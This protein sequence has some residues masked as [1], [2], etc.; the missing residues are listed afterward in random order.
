MRVATHRQVIPIS[1]QEVEGVKLRLAQGVVRRAV[2]AEGHHIELQIGR[3]PSSAG[4]SDP[5]G[6]HK[7]GTAQ[8]RPEPP[9]LAGESWSRSPQGG[10]RF[11]RWPGTGSV[12][13]A[14]CFCETSKRVHSNR[15]LVRGFGPLRRRQAALVRSAAPRKQDY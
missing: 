6:Q 12:M 4:K 3:S 5:S 10:V 14:A 9:A 2:A 8:N 11:G 13:Q 15:T 7:P 1:G